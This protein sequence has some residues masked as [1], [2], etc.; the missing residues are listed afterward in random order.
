MDSLSIQ[1]VS[2]AQAAQRSGRAGRIQAGLTFR[3]YTEEAFQ[4]LAANS[5][6][7]AFPKL[8]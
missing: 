5:R 2:Q 7:S 4:K 3:L 8:L 1:P 6:K